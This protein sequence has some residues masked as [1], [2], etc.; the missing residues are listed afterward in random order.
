MFN[1]MYLRIQKIETHLFPTKEQQLK[2]LVADSN[3]P[4][5]YKL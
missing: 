3:W 1:I 2:L 4:D 5:N